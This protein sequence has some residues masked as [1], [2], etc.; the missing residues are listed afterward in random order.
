MKK[1]EF[2]ERP[3][4]SGYRMMFADLLNRHGLEHDLCFDWMVAA[5]DK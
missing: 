2:E 5:K 3:D 1:L 4:Y